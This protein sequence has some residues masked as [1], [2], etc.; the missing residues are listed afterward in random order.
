[1]ILHP[2]IWASSQTFWNSSSSN[3]SSPE[4][5]IVLSLKHILAIV[6][7]WRLKASVVQYRFTEHVPLFWLSPGSLIAPDVSP[8]QGTSAS[9]PHPNLLYA[10]IFCFVFLLFFYKLKGPCRNL[11]AWHQ[12]K[13]NNNI[14]K[15]D[16]ST[17]SLVYMWYLSNNF[18]ASIYYYIQS[19]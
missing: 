1:M 14:K 9:S 8:L 11:P 16:A 4:Q 12:E 18:L 3:S 5:Y 19:I 6:I 2:A 13:T 10:S 15:K 7:R 17:F